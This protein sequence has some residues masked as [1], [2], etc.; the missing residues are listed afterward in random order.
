MTQEEK[1]KAYD[2]VSKEVKDFFEGRQK[3]YS[4]VN[5]TLEYLFPELKESEDEKVRDERIRKALI[6]GFTVMKESKNCGK[7]FSNHNIPVADILAWLENQKDCIK[8]SNSAYTSNRDVIKFADKY[9]HIVW[10]KLMDKF[11]KIENYSIGCNDVSDIVLNAIINTYN[12]LKKQ[13]EQGKDILEDAILDGNEDGLIAET[14]RYKN[15]KQAEQ[16]QTDRVKPKFKVGDWIINPRTGLIK[17]IKNVLLC[18]N[19]G[20]YEFESSSMSIDS[21]DNSF[22]LWTIQDAKDGDVLVTRKKQ[23]FIFKNYDEDT[24][25]IYAYCGICDLVKDNSFYADDDQ[26]WTCYSVAGDVYPA[27]KEQCDL[28]FQKMKEAGYEWDDKNK[29]LKK[30]E[31]KPSD[32]TPYPETLEKAIDLYYYSYGNGKGEFEH[33][34]L[35]KFKDIVYT[36]VS[37]YGQKPV[38]WSEE[39]EDYINDLIKYFS[40]NERLK[41]TKED[42]VIWL[43]SLRPQKCLIPSEEEIEK[44]AQE[45]ESKA[46]FNPFYMTT[47][48]DKPTGVKQHITTH[49]ESFKAGV[50]WILK[51]LKVQ[52]KQKWSDVDK[53]ILSRIIDDLKFLRDTVSIDPKYAVSII[54]MEREITW[55]NSLKPQNKWKPSDEQMEALDWQVENTSVSSWQY[56]ATKEL[57]EDLKKLKEDKYG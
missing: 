21:V 11:K 57:M 51:S 26:L 34:S 19:N 9:S 43:K 18:D 45:W 39:D 28:L 17:H 16:N 14:I 49:K 4:D 35:E 53:D 40:Q 54:D 2:R 37:N 15:E 30:I 52:P 20:N 7:T 38:E 12:W 50:N 32:E 48:G 25:Y 44:A 36:F 42:I 22:H 23:P 24:D 47:E 33:L 8:L 6:D 27:T 31:K 3:M 29:E 56:K 5:Q 13:S 1:A 46:N 55:L 41:N 10:E